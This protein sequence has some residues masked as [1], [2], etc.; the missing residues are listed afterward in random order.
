MDLPDA[1]IDALLIGAEELHRARLVEGETEQAKA[2]ADDAAWAQV[3]RPFVA[4]VEAV[5]PLPL[6]EWIDWRESMIRVASDTHG[7]AERFE[8]QLADLWVE[9]ECPGCS[10]VSITFLMRGPGPRVAMFA[11]KENDTMTA[12]PTLYHALAV[13]REA[14]LKQTEYDANHPL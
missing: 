2:K 7:A 9:L 4:A 8:I 13:A 5:V 14:W 3:W 1:V 10:P 6:R 12:Y 11:A